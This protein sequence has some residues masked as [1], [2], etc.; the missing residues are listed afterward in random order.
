[1]TIRWNKIIVTD[2]KL[3]RIIQKFQKGRQETEHLKWDFLTA[4]S[5]QVGL[6]KIDLKK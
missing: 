2:A 6:K 4:I 5:L 3:E 1:M